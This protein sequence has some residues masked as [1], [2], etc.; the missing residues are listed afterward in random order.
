VEEENNNNNVVD[1]T[2]AGLKEAAKLAS[3]LRGVWCFAVVAE[4]RPM[5]GISE[6]FCMVFDCNVVVVCC[7]ERDKVIAGRER[8]TWMLWIIAF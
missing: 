7:R 3:R 6:V 2:E 4:L 8:L 1:F 5:F